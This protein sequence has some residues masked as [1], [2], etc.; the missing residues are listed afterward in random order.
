MF[1]EPWGPPRADERGRP[2]RPR[3]S[4]WLLCA[5][6]AC[7]L[8]GA[9]AV[10]AQVGSVG[11]TAGGLRLPSGATSVTAEP[12]T[13]HPDV[14]VAASKRKNH[15]RLTSFRRPLQSRLRWC[16]PRQRSRVPHA[17]PTQGP[18]PIRRRRRYQRADGANNKPSSD[19][20]HGQSA[21]REQRAEKL[22][23]VATHDDGSDRVNDDHGDDTGCDTNHGDDWAAVRP[24]AMCQLALLLAALGPVPGRAAATVFHL[25][26]DTGT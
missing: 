24:G 17:R 11:Q 13:P 4:G 7:L 21:A 15:Q 10:Q 1:P 19:R 8:V 9:V 16:P 2:P 20:D 14:T 5:F 3:V 12:N 23:D 22:D 18:P 26:D 25:V 6:G